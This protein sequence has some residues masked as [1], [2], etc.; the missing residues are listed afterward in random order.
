MT[1]TKETKGNTMRNNSTRISQEELK[2]RGLKKRP[3]RQGEKKTATRRKKK[4]W[5]PEGPAM[6]RHEE[7][8]CAKKRPKNTR[9]N[10]KK[11]R[12]LS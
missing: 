4:K 9:P 3:D 11:R 12:H 8:K 5:R 6:K 2:Q 7:R 1:A 10:I